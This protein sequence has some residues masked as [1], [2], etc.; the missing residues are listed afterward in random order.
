MAR[1]GE[2]PGPTDRD[3]GV[4]AGR[5]VARRFESP[6]GFVV[7]V[8]RTAGDNDVLT[9]K[10]GARRD[11][12]LHVAADSGSHVVVRNPGGVASLPRDTAQFAAGL[13]A[14]YSK[15]RAGGRVAVHLCTCAD[16]SKPRGLPPGKVHIERY[17][18][19]HAAPIREG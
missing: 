15:L 10:I 16:V 8:G 6:D 9:F 1:R 3:A 18:T 12:W 5:S 14:G 17:K 11:F 13:A 2:P 4:W 19:M 7:L